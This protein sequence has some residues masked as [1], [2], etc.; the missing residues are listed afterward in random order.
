MADHDD[1]ADNE[2]DEPNGGSEGAVGPDPA[3]ED[4]ATA[5]VAKIIDTSGIYK[6]IFQQL[7][8]GSA[9][10]LAKWSR[11]Q[12]LFGTK[13][14]TAE[15][16]KSVFPSGL[17]GYVAG[18]RSMDQFAGRERLQYLKTTAQLSESVIG[19]GTMA[20]WRTS[21]QLESVIS[22]MTK[23]PAFKAA[24]SKSWSA[25]EFRKSLGFTARRQVYMTDWLAQI[26]FGRGLLSEISSRPISLY[27]DY[28]VG[29]GTNPTR[30]QIGS[31]V[32]TGQ[33]VNGLLGADALSSE[34][35]R[36]DSDLELEVADRVETD[37]LAPH[38]AGRLGALDELRQALESIDSKVVEMLE[39]GWHV[40]QQAPPAAAEMAA[41][42][43]VEALDRALRAA[44]PDQAV[45]SWLPSS[46]RPEREW[47]S[48]NG[49]LTRAI[50]IRYIM[51]G[52]KRETKLTLSLVDNVIVL[53]DQ[54][55]SGAQALKH[56]SVGDLAKARC[57]LM[58]A[59]NI[60]SML[61]TLQQD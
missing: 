27:R 43:V 25:E 17:T 53:Q 38:Q 15:A 47:R 9:F 45:E 57:L 49:R 6:E 58:A 32:Y 18:L 5:A 56:A 34:A 10:Q 61:F 50:R 29:L 35:V 42:C 39:G 46:G 52:H 12:D 60:L 19:P 41:N 33:S 22:E 37:L 24:A 4:S 48:P 40:V 26:D 20:A 3:G 28:L 55:S 54:T 44:A 2:D 13:K 8:F 30:S 23:G 16:M 51:Q 31:S 7:G 36:A 11:D 59:E 21:L 1:V 14:L